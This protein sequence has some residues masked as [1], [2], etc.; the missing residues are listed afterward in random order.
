MLN[1]VLSLFFS[2]VLHNLEEKVVVSDGMRVETAQL[3]GDADCL[4]Q[5]LPLVAVQAASATAA[6][7][8]G[9]DGEGGA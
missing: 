4:L 8:K 9:E 3:S 2:R 1:A 7:R 5:A 6:P